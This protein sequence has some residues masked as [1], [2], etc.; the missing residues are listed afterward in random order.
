[1]LGNTHIANVVRRLHK[2]VWQEIGLQLPSNH[3]LV[4]VFD[5][6]IA[7]KVLGFEYEEI[8]EIPNW[9][10]SQN[11]RTAGLVDPQQELIQIS[12]QFPPTV[13]RFT[14]AHEIGHVLLHPAQGLH[15]ER[16]VEAPSL[17]T[18]QRRRPEERQADTFASLYLMPEKLLRQRIHETF[19]ITPPITITDEIAFWLDPNEQ[20]EVLREPASSHVSARRFA[21][22]SNNFRGQHIIPLHEQFKVSISAMAYRIE[23]LRLLVN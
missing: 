12:E 14:G 13:R 2:K 7:A 18:R 16:P 10:P 19:S 5:P 9:P 8:P 11:T 17:H 22:C 20:Q 23:E 1:M 3:D 4:D 6:S 21:K 15:R